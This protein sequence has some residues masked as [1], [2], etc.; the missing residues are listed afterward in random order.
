MT[1]SYI[2]LHECHQ[3]LCAAEPVGSSGGH[4]GRHEQRTGGDGSCR[5]DRPQP[6]GIVT[7]VA[8]SAEVLPDLVSYTAA[9]R[10][11]PWRAWPSAV[12][13]LR[14]LSQFITPDVIAFNAAL[15]AVSGS[16]RASCQLLRQMCTHSIRCDIITGSMLITAFS[17]GNM[18][19][20]SF[21]VLLWS[22]RQSSSALGA[23][24]AEHWRVALQQ[25]QLV[26]RDV[27]THSILMKSFS[28]AE[29]WPLSLCVFEKMEAGS[30]S[31]VQLVSL[32]ELCVWLNLVAMMLEHQV[33][34]DAISW[35]NKLEVLQWLGQDRFTFCSLIKFL[36]VI[37]FASFVAVVTRWHLAVSRGR[38]SDGPMCSVWP[39]TASWRKL[40]R[41][42]RLL[43]PWPGS[44]WRT[45][46]QSI[47]AW[48][49]RLVPWSR[50]LH[51][52]GA[53]DDVR[54][55]TRPLCLCSHVLPGG[56]LFLV[57]VCYAWCRG[58]ST[59][60]CTDSTSAAV[61][62]ASDCVSCQPLDAMLV[63]VRAEGFEHS[64]AAADVLGGQG[65]GWGSRLV[66][67]LRRS[68]PRR[69]LRRP[70]APPAPPDRALAALAEV[71]AVSVFC[72]RSKRRR[73]SA[74]SWDF[75]CPRLTSWASL[76]PA[77]FPA[78]CVLA[79][80]RHPIS[81]Q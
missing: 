54:C 76:R 58:R 61:C 51:R 37:F 2:R 30:V 50:Q 46:L 75:L 52:C 43:A 67:G 39:G 55:V 15:V 38:P 72:C 8:T 81:E 5:H 20:L 9:L 64:G 13:L 60:R 22:R 47:L 34:P 19:P 10:A 11:C 45:R 62:M 56:V 53:C 77:S 32:L 33:Q 16:W 57:V 79:S 42:F 41:R 21:Q 65:Q 71:S 18:W 24:P 69:C 25:Q 49:M 12:D 29:E 44:W 6:F 17:S 27:A 35:Q 68:L 14:S 80:C 4:A 78:V 70:G 31:R 66:M 3:S 74:C 26:P 28:K 1:G 73:L 63:A 48:C 7:P 40:T 36:S 59:P 23:L